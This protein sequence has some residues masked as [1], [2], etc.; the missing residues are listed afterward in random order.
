MT[1]ETTSSVVKK[2]RYRMSC[3]IQFE[4]LKITILDHFYYD[5]KRVPNEKRLAQSWYIFN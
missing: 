2:K 3:N 5:N 4:F 1:L